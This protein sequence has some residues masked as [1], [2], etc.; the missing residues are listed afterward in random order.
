MSHAGRRLVFFLGAA[1]LAV[2]LLGA[3]NG[4]PAFGHFRGAYGIWL[5]KVAV[6][7]RHVTD[8]VAGVNFDYRGIDTLG[9]E[10][11]LFAAASGVL[12]VL[13]ELRGESGPAATISSD[14]RLEGREVARMGALLLAPV[15]LVQAIEVI[16]HGQVDPGG[17]FQGGV[18]VA[19]AV[20]MV[21][22]SGDVSRFRRSARRGIMET[23]EATGAA[24]F[25]VTGL[26]GLFV[27]GMFFANILPL[28]PI[29]GVDSAGTIA[30]LNAVVGLEVAGGIAVV[31]AEFV[32]QL[33][34]SED[35]PEG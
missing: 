13:R 11:I 22:L 4:L 30:L 29:G 1:A 33:H 20:A 19:S 25:V 31:I 32:D 3:S 28:G 14:E 12:L 7:Q 16:V 24:G 8:V 27:T 5:N 15:I 34:S 6:G 35:A 21:Y 26:W 18:L 2:A 23:T 10:Y 9:E 17:G